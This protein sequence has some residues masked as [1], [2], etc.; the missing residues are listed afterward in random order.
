V[1]DCISVIEQIIGDDI[2]DCREMMMEMFKI[3]DQIGSEENLTYLL[4]L[5]AGICI[6][7]KN[8]E[9]IEKQ[10]KLSY[11]ESTLKKVFIE[12]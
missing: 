10:L 7:K 9:A 4:K 2:M 8:L 11:I 6:K 1:E 3:I 5:G 12:Y